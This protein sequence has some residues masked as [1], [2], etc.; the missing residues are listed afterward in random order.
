MDASKDYYAILGVLPTAEDIVIRAAYKA[1]AQRYHPDRSDGNKEEAHRRMVEINEAYEVLSNIA[2][3]KEY[4]KVRGTNTQSGDSYFGENS[5]DTPPAFDPLERDW[6]IALKYYPDLAKLDKT[7]LRI[8]WRLAYSFRAHLLEVKA[9]DRRTQVAEA[10]EQK[11]L[12]TYFGTDR[13]ILQFARTLINRGHKAAAKALNEAVRVLGKSVEV[14]RIIDQIRTEFN[15][16][17]PTDNPGSFVS[18]AKTMRGLGL[19]ETE[20]TAQ[21]VSRGVKRLVAE[22]IAYMVCHDS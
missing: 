17:K 15:I 7:L 6:R 18:M 19:K 13:D 10:L 11:F 20:I 16:D 12:E 1:L 3:R 14:E 9:F 22:G 5:G 21:L 2:S 4:D 8:S